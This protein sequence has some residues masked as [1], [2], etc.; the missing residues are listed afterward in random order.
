MS[1]GV[2]K[3]SVGIDGFDLISEGGIPS[4]RS[5]LVAGTAGS[6]KTIFAVQFLVEGIRKFDQNGVFL[7]FEEEP[8]EIARNVRSFGWD[9][10]QYVADE[11]LAF[12]DASPEPGEEQVETGPFDF[13]ALL[14]RIETAIG[15]TGAKRVVIDSVG[16][17]F[18]KFNDPNLIRREL[19]RIVMGLRALGVT[20]VITMERTDE[21]GEIGRYG[22]EEFVAD[23]VVILRNQLEAEKR[24]RTIEILKIRGASHQKGEFPFTVDSRDGVTVIPLSAIEL[25]QNSS[26]VRISSGNEEL[27]SMCKGGMFRDSIIL[28]SGATGTGK[29]L[30]VTE[31]MKA[32]IKGNERALLFAFEES[33]EQ[34]VRNAASW[35][36]DYAASEKAGRL[37][38]VCRYPETMGLEDHLIRMK[39]EIEDFKPSRIAVDSMS[40]LERGATVK[41]FR[42]FVIGITS[43]I[44]KMETAGMFT[45][46]TS[47]L[48]GGESITETHISTIT[49]SIILLRYVELQGEMRRGLTVLKMRGSW[50]EKRIREYVIDED[51]MHIQSSFRGVN[52]ILSGT[53]TYSL[54]VEAER[55]D[56]MFE[57]DPR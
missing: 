33:R 31:F 39:R 7:T 24:R 12:V 42:E 57:A 3:L 30:M 46:T 2:E 32:A 13:S 8:K 34:L 47:M 17:A 1:K 10:E 40:A 45:N 50:H 9:L 53:P 23:N 14:A 54:G 51:G 55:L 18:P 6:G 19:H 16:A 37:K 20:T 11:K 15:R 38:I 21:Y 49:D 26:T 28:V 5:T 48:L 29:T 22:I 25:T 41:S 4:Q 36:V 56:S 52:G 27:D 44:K 43:H 35:G